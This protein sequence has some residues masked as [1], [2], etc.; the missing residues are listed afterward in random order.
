MHL[1]PNELTLLYNEE[2]S[3]DK[4]TLSYAYTI[5]DRI[6][7]QELHSVKVSSTLFQIMV[8]K[9][10]MEPKTLINKADPY[11]QKNI[12]GKNFSIEEWFDVL[13]NHPQLLKA[14]LAMYRNKAVICNTPT[15]ILRLN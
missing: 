4:K 1:N 2:N 13:M 12:R 9:L 8:E 10:N 7:K 5:T 15:D 11:Y 3:R 14:P 6:N